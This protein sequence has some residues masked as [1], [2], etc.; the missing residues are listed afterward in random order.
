MVRKRVARRDDHLD[1]THIGSFRGVGCDHI[2][3]DPLSAR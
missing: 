1:R 3:A 2:E